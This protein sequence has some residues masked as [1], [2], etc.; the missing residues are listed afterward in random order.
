MFSELAEQL[1]FVQWVDRPA[2]LNQ[3]F[4]QT[5]S[6]ALWLKVLASGVIFILLAFALGWRG[7]LRT[8]S[9][10]LLAALTAAACLGWLGQTLTLFSVFGLLL[11]TAIGVDYAII[12]Y[13][14]VGGAATSLLGTLLAAVTTW[15][16]FGL[17]SLSN[18]PAVSSF[19]LAVSLGLIF[20]FLFAPW[21]ARAEPRTV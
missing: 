19:G 6:H 1:P 4:K 18:T 16:S 11:V 17:L 20:S 12:V 7:A 2:E 3:L 8:L 13:E 21:A 15:L 10:S 14:N 9:V 5:Q